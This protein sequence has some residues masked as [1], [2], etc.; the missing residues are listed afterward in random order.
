M[1]SGLVGLD[2]KRAAEQEVEAG[3]E[4]GGETNT[5]RT[6]E[7]PQQPDCSRTASRSLWGTRQRQTGLHASNP[8]NK[9]QSV[10][11]AAR[12]YLA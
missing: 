1:V 8:R 3:G 2:R 12:L 4:Q 6:P 10:A 11:P 7:Q 5:Y 9:S